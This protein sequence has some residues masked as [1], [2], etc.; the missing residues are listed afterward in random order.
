MPLFMLRFT[1]DSSRSLSRTF[2]SASTV[3]TPTTA[4][5]KQRPTLKLAMN[6]F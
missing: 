6:S 2:T 4:M 5:I 1:S 3:S